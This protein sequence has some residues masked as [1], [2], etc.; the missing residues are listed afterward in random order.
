MWQ[1]YV[2]RDRV[3]ASE[4]G[5]GNGDSRVVELDARSGD[6]QGELPG[7]LVAQRGNT[8]VTINSHHSCV[9]FACFYED[10]MAVRDLVTGEG[11]GFGVY[12]SFGLDPGSQI[13][14]LGA[15]RIYHAGLGPTAPA[16]HSRAS[17]CGP[18]RPVRPHPV[19]ASPL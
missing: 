5:D 16:T 8:A 7:V 9:R 3:L 17:G 19:A 11:R 10:T 2:W 6:V 14:T 13:V 1:P 15:D 18:T 12:N 4:E